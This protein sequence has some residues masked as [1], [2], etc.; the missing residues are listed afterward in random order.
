MSERTVSKWSSPFKG[1]SQT[2]RLRGKPLISKQLEPLLPPGNPTQIKVLNLDRL[3]RRK[4]G[5]LT[6]VVPLP[7]AKLSEVSSRDYLIKAVKHQDK[8]H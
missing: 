7:V 3:F 2:Q 5:K 4:D 1:E 8:I 6:N